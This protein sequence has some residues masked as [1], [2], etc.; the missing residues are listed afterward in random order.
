MTQVA[1]GII[2]QHESAHDFSRVLLCQRKPTSRY[3]LKWEFPGGKVED[4]E[5]PE[6]CVRREVFEELGIKAEAGELFH[7]QH[8][9]YPDTGSFDVYYYLISPFIGTIENNVFE[10][11][12]WVSISELL[13]FDILEGNREVVQKLQSLHGKVISDKN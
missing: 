4:G 6:D 3:P 9:V 7:R 8:T 12:R 1:V 10:T 11:I 2:I 13:S 5:S